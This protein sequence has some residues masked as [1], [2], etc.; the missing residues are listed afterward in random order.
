MPAARAPGT[1]VSPSASRASASCALSRRKGTPWARACRG[2]SSSCALPTVNAS[3]PTAAPPMKSRR[4]IISYLPVACLYRASGPACIR[5][6]STFGCRC[7]FAPPSPWSFSTYAR[8]PITPQPG[9]AWDPHGGRRERD[10]RTEEGYP[11][12]H[13][14]TSRRSAGPGPGTDAGA[15]TLE[16]RDCQRQRFC[17]LS[18]S[19]A[20]AYEKVDEMRGVWSA[21]APDRLRDEGPREDRLSRYVQGVW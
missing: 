16:L 9:L 2:V 17:T 4:L 14:P 3:A 1:S 13:P 7:A 6:K 10:E 21:D 12:V 5:T 20:C 18:D 19:R 11:W 8:S 15:S